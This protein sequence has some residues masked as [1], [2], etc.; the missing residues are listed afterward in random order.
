MCGE[1]QLTRKSS[2]LWRIA[3]SYIGAI[4]LLQGCAGQLAKDR[5]ALSVNVMSHSGGADL[6]LETTSGLF[7]T[8]DEKFFIGGGGETC[9]VFLSDDD[10]QE[11]LRFV[12][13]RTQPRTPPGLA[14][15]LNNLEEGIRFSI[16]S[17]E[18]TALFWDG[19]LIRLKDR[20]FV[21]ISDHQAGEDM[22][23]LLIETAIHNGCEE[24]NLPPP[25]PIE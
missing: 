5:A 10:E 22:F 6:H 23:A 2:L 19:G 9:A 18:G 24:G 14:E 25:R 7:R 3:I 8:P 13:L 15:R 17:A 16:R 21:E 20:S 11:I 4:A 12:S 1:L